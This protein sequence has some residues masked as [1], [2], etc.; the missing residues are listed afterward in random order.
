MT[1]S[2]H[3]TSASETHLIA[4]RFAAELRRGDVVALSGELGSGKTQFVQG[5]AEYFGVTEP[6]TSPT[7][8]LLNRY[9]GLDDSRDELFLYHFDFYRIR[10]AKELYDLGFEEVLQHDGIVL[11]EWANSFP[12]LLPPQRIDISF[13]HGSADQEREI[14][15]ERVEE[16]VPVR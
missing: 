7:F 13:R 1:R 5:V 10:S 16:Q 14:N 9:A 11:I 6:V 4:G 12:A 15:V 8:V 3:S 2:F